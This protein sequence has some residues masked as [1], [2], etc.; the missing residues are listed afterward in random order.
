MTA[1]RLR[2]VLG[3]PARPGHGRPYAGFLFDIKYAEAFNHQ[4]EYAVEGDP[5]EW[6]GSDGRRSRRQGVDDWTLKSRWKVRAATSRRWW[7]TQL[8][9]P[10]PRWAV[11]EHGDRVGARA[12]TFP[13]VSN[14]PF[15]LDPWEHDVKIEMSKNE[16]FWD[17]EN[18]KLDR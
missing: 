17:A 16:D 10:A 8:P 2:L 6:P 9:F 4:T 13:I 12:A 15:K 11:E 1:A 14:G 18:I 7:P 3:P 5:L